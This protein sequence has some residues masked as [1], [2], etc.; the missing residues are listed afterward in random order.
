MQTN[1]T[2]PAVSGA[3]TAPAAAPMQLHR[4]ASTALSPLSTTDIAYMVGGKEVKL[5]VATIKAYLVNGNADAVT[6]QECVMY[7]MMCQH[8]GLDPFLREA[9]L[10]K[11]DAKSP[12]QMVTGKEA[13]MKRAERN[14]AFDGYE[15]GIIVLC[16]TGEV[17]YREGCAY[18]PGTEAQPEEQLLGG[19][20]KVY[21]KDR[22]R[23][24]YESVNLGE[25]D[26]HQ[27]KWKEAPASMIRKVALVHALREAFPMDL[28]GLYSAEELGVA[29]ADFEGSANVSDADD[30]EQRVKRLNAAASARRRP[31]RIDQRAVA[32]PAPLPDAPADE[33][34]GDPFGGD[35]E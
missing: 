27:S 16:E 24:Y 2:R 13:F 28:G 32:E 29:E 31:A 3:A 10:I 11:Y 35:G 20:A 9:Y 12:A 21:R 14:P 25:Y 22:T 18:W 1:F 8:A 17:D 26:K 15:A 23:P 30:T 7:G 34:E 5:D 33:P 19:W 4:P 6:D